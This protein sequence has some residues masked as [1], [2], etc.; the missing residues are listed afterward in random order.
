MKVYSFPLVYTMWCGQS[1]SWTNEMKDNFKE[2]VFHAY[3]QTLISGEAAEAQ[4]NPDASRLRACYQANSSL[5]EEI[6]LNIS[7]IPTENS[8]TNN[9]KHCES[10]KWKLMYIM[11][12]WNEHVRE[13]L[14]KELSIQNGSIIRV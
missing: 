7:L 5:Y 10:L 14:W 13:V 8:A 3:L 1:T 12:T 6:L 11:P 4:T 2:F 9:R